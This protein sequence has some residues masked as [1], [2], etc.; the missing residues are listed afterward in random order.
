MSTDTNYI[1]YTITIGAIIFLCLSVFIIFLIVFLNLKV[2]RHHLEKKDIE[3]AK[4][5]ELLNATFEA[6]EVERQ[7]IGSDIHDDIGP[8]LSTIK[9]YLNKFRYTKN[10][11]DVEIEIK[12]LN[13]QLDEIVKRI[14]VVAK[15]LVPAVLMEFGLISAIEDLCNRINQSREIHAD[16]ITNV[17]HLN[18]DEK[19]KLALYR[20]IQ[21]LCNNS[22]KH[23]FAKKMAITINKKEDLLEISVSDS[24]KGFNVE[25][26]SNGLGLKNIQARISLI[27]A[28]Y[29]IE[30]QTN[31]G[32][33]ATIQLSV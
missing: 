2:Y 4:Q 23:A 29:K 24:G 18:L 27:K 31:V 6:Q 1:E 22:I 28:K 30:S 7:R 16:L 26:N 10:K 3:N 13:T 8:L 15:D 14:R 20:I 33:I 17:E 21:E 25:I 19:T 32:T 12:N 11:D 9:L 5:E